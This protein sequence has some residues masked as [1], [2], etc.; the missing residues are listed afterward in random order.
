M[1]KLRIIKIKIKYFIYNFMI[2]IIIKIK[3]NT[4]YLQL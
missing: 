3:L 1:K 4:I 2:K